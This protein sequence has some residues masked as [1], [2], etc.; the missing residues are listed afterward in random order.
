M[1]NS[2]IYKDEYSKILGKIYAQCHRDP[3]YKKRFLD[4]PKAVI[5]EE[6]VE[7]PDTIKIKAVEESDPNVLTLHLP[8]KPSE[9]LSDRDLEQ[10][11]GGKTTVKEHDANRH[12]F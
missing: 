10:V 1:S 12:A 11:A 8:P 2:F 3:E 6:G 7:V 9:E 4:D 5:K